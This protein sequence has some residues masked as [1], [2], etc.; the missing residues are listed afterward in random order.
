MVNKSKANTCIFCLQRNEKQNLI[1][2][3]KTLLRFINS[4]FKALKKNY[5]FDIYY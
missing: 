1:K 2:Q 5:S 3:S 4:C